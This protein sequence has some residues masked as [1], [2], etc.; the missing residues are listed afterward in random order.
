MNPLTSPPI[1]RG[2]FQK[3]TNL[4][5]LFDAFDHPIIILDNELN[6]VFFNSKTKTISDLSLEKAL[7]LPC[8]YF[9]KTRHC[10]HECPLKKPETKMENNFIETDILNSFRQIIPVK[11]LF[12]EIYDSSANKQ[13]YIL[14]VKK[15][16]KEK[17]KT[18]NYQEDLSF[19]SIIGRSPEMA[20]IYRLL[21]VLAQSDASTLITGETG[22][23]KDLLAEEMHR[24]SERSEG[25]FIKVNCGALPETLLESEL[26]GHNKGAFTGAVENKPGRFKLAH[27]GTLFLTEIGDLPLTLQVKLLTFL[28][29][30]VVYPLGSTKG[31]QANVRIIAATHRNLEQMVG[32]GNFRQDLLFRLNVARIHL[33]PLRERDDDLLLLLNH[34]LKKFNES[35]NKKISGFNSRAKS[36]LVKYTYP[37]NV[38]EVRNIIEYAAN[39]CQ[40]SKIAPPDLPAY[41]QHRD[42]PSKDTTSGSEEVLKHSN[43]D[44]SEQKETTIETASFS[45]FPEIERK[46][47][48]DA[49]LKSGGSKSKAAEIL[50]WGRTTLWRKMKKYEIG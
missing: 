45:S 40:N 22:T 47:I 1:A 5:K 26:F 7:G 39:V 44:K 16:E 8:R 17:N 9:L 24:A 27:N 48:I 25:P 15:P 20:K 33:P 14:I 6:L 3:G 10:G 18:K 46:L 38:R 43:P 31:F 13:G 4:E 49:L 37:G 23:G 41:I 28:D 50:G 2:L 34:F 36:I 30:K 12:S 29:D 32:E 11:I 19:S 21:P 35:L 42:K